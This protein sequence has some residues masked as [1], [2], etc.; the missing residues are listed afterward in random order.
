MPISATT[1]DQIARHTLAVFLNTPDAQ[2]IPGKRKHVL[3]KYGPGRNRMEENGGDPIEIRYQ[4]DDGSRARTMK[5]GTEDVYNVKDRFE[6]GT[7]QW[8]IKGVT[9]AFSEIIKSRSRG[10]K[11]LAD[12]VKGEIRQNV[13]AMVN[14]IEEEAVTVPS[15]SSDT[16]S[17]LGV[18]YHIRRLPSGTTSYEGTFGGTTIRFADGTTSTTHQGLSTATF[19]LLS[20]FAFTRTANMAD[21][22]DAMCRAMIRTAIDGASDLA[23]LMNYKDARYIILWSE[24]DQADYE[25]LI[26]ETP[27]FKNGDYRRFKENGAALNV[28]GVKC[29]GVEEFNTQAG[30]PM[31]CIDLNCL[32]FMNCSGW[33]MRTTE[34]AQVP[35]HHLLSGRHWDCQLQQVSVNPRFHGFI[36]TDQW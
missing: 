4:I 14:T 2:Y 1:M 29:Y 3:L 10:A 22:V 19:P 5:I 35:W 28:R 25:R 31:V 20:N 24:H 8:S 7:A 21:D 17:I 9:A 26:N 12:Y 36:G 13:A 34:T 18:L 11:A 33:W 32:K 23:S 6:K 27:D 30:R 16:D 15:T